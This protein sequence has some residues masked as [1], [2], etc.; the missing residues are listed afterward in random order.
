MYHLHYVLLSVAVFNSGSLFSEWFCRPYY[1]DTIGID[2]SHGTTSACGSV[3]TLLIQGL[4]AR[5]AG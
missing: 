4:Q 3:C 1:K 5:S 2:C